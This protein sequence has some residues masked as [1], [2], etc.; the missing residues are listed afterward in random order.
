MRVLSIFI[1]IAIAA[2]GC[3][4]NKQLSDAYGNFTAVEITVSAETS[5]KVLS[6]NIEEGNRIDKGFVSYR[7]DSIQTY[8]KKQ[9]L[10]ARCRGVA[11][12]RISIQAQI[13]VLKEQER[14]VKT[15]LDRFEK[16]LPEDAVSQ[17]QVDDLENNLLVLQ[18]QIDQVNTNFIAIN[19]EV[20][21]IDAGI[22]QADDMLRRTSVSSPISGVVLETYAEEGETVVQGKPLFKIADLDTMKLKAYF[23]AKQLAKLKLGD[24]VKVL[25]DDGQGGLREYDGQI[26]WIASD[27]EFTPKIIQTREERVNLVYAVNIYVVNDGLIRINMPGEVR[28]LNKG[29]VT[30]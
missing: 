10:L 12:K 6:K 11:A 8:L 14:A 17:K 27:A 13:S 25:T 3:G 28:L 29:V 23:S 22:K 5:G 18:K 21:S 1:I 19:A 16:L 9:E 2:Q 30:E 26:R 20:E 7:I 15:D 4:R 24:A